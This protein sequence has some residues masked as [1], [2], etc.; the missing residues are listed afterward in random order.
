MIGYA[1]EAELGDSVETL[2]MLDES[3]CRALRDQVYRLQPHWVQRYPNLPMYSLGAA[4]F[5]DARLGDGHYEE[6]VA[7]YNP[8]LQENFGLLYER[9]ARVLSARLGGPVA[10]APDK[11]LPNFWIFLAHPAFT[12][13]SPS[14][15]AD[16]QYRQT[17]WAWAKSVSRPIT[18][19][20]PLSLPRCGSGL[21]VWDLS[22]RRL[23]G[24][25]KAEAARA[26]REANKRF[27]EYRLGHLALQFGH[28]LHQIATP[29]QLDD[30][31]ERMT[32]QGHG[33]F[34]DGVWQL[35]C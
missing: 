27:I 29:T 5:T 24:A 34:C 13:L 7:T 3:E 32:F 17:D 15:H 8:V 18:F 10:Y 35:Y 9:L 6:A 23:D 16:L 19:T 25:P 22:V 11:G 31:D 14:V 33:L 21:N 26:F 30:D 12:L 4:L 2:A 20:L 28:L 1:D